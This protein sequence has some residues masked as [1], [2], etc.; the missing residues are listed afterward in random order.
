MKRDLSWN[1]LIGASPRAVS[2]RKVVDLP[3]DFRNLKISEIRPS[4]RLGGACKT[5]LNLSQ[6]SP[7]LS[8]EGEEWLQKNFSVSSVA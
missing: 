4:P 1:Q 6:P 2:P 8:L 7:D 5:Q 3:P